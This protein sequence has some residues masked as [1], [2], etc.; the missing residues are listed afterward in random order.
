MTLKRDAIVGFTGILGLAGLAT[1]LILFGEFAWGSVERYSVTLKL[2]SAQDLRPGSV[3]TLNGVQIGEIA[4]TR[5]ASDP[6]L[7]VEVD[8]SIQDT[9][10]IPRAVDVTINRDFVGSTRLA[11][12]TLPP[13]EGPDG[14]VPEGG[15][16]EGR[17]EGLLDQIGALLDQ[18]IQPFGD[19]A[20]SVRRLADTYNEVGE[21]VNGMLDPAAADIDA[22]DA[23]PNIVRT[24]AKLE[25][26]VDD[27]RVW[28]GDEQL[29]TRFADSVTQA[30][31]TL[32]EVEAAAAE[33]RATTRRLE[34]EALAVRGDA[35]DATDAF[36]AAANRLDEALVAAQRLLEDARTGDGAIAMLVNNPDIYR[37]VN[38]ASVRLEQML[39]E[40]KLLMQKYRTE[41]IDI[42]F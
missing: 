34:E 21:R 18:R 40:A 16:I 31:R 36:I 7:G 2:N 14:F 17:A 5:T 26:A 3:V 41:G 19:A 11:L 13:G 35:R 29:R 30:E 20:D 10:R 28:L 38:N 33:F 27:A 32:A 37:N 23:S 12:V 6:R 9:Q 4:S 1:M 25:A 8:M 22:A 15:E 42:D 39:A 24:I